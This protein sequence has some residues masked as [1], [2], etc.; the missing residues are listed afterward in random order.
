MITRCAER[1]RVT[2]QTWGAVLNIVTSL[3]SG[4]LTAPLAERIIGAWRD[5]ASPTTIKAT[6]IKATTMKVR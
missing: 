4:P 2:G 6:T 1:W 3:K 5:A